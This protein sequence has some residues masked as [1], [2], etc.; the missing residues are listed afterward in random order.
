MTFEGFTLADTEPGEESQCKLI[1]G[2]AIAVQVL[3]ASV[4]LGSLI[5]KRQREH[6]R[7]PFI[8]WAMDTSK[9][10]VAAGM[11]HF[12]N[13]ALAYIADSDESS[14][15]CV[16]YSL[17]I[18]LDTTLGVGVLALLLTAFHRAANHIGISDMQSGQYGDPPRFSAWFRQLILFLTAWFFVKVF[19]VLLLK[20]F[21]FL[22]TMAAWVL[23]PLARDGDTKLQTVVVMFIF[24]LIM[25]VVQAWLIDMVIKGKRGKVRLRSGSVGGDSD[26]DSLVQE[27]EFIDDI[28][29][30]AGNFTDFHDDVEHGRRSDDR[31]GRLVRHSSGSSQPLLKVHRTTPR[32][33]PPSETPSD[34]FPFPSSLDATNNLSDMDLDIDKA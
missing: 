27:E 31:R 1:D 23:D 21:P 12:A 34:G 7:R 3:M 17:N 10:A 5:V 30:S 19:V 8:I 9:Q 13:I 18:L 24:P 22:A 20:V 28:E 14:N 15:P 29:G 4:A 32:K 2:F 16:W 33:S 11:V 6:P 25:N 26:I